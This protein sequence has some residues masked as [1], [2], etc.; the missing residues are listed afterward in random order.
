MK[1]PYQ[2][3]TKAKMT[4][5]N[6]NSSVAVR[7]EGGAGVLQNLPQGHTLLRMWKFQIDNNKL[8]GLDCLSINKN[9]PNDSI[10]VDISWR[11]GVSRKGREKKKW[12]IKEMREKKIRAK[13]K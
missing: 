7:V 3:V 9:E 4:Y 11:E 12:K 8:C 6:S 2:Y 13:G 5:F 1:I 10:E